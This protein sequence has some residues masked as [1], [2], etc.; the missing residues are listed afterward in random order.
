M[1]L[2]KF[3]FDLHADT[4]ESKPPDWE[5]DW[6]DAPLTYK[7]YRRRPVVPLSPEVPLTL[8]G[9]ESPAGPDL[10]AIGHLLWHAYG[11]GR[12][13][14]YAPA[15]SV[16]S[17]TEPLQLYRR[18]VPSGGGLYPNELYVY[19]KIADV[20][21]GIYHYDAAH[22]RLA[23][24]REGNF[25][26]YLSR[27]LGNRCDMPGCFAAVFVSVMFWKNFYKYNNFAYRLQGLDSGVLI[28]QLL[29]VAKRFGFESGVY[30]QFLDRAIHHLLGVT[31]REESV[32]AIVPLSTGPAASW[33]HN[34][35]NGEKAVFASDLCRELPAVRHEHFVRSQNVKEY[36]MLARMNEASMLDRA[37]SFRCV[38]AAGFVESGLQAI[39][40]PSVNRL[41]YDLATVCRKRY[42]P[43]GEFVLSHI[44]L[45]NAA[46]LLREA[47]DSLDY[48]NDLN[49]SPDKVT[50]R[51]SL[52]C[53]L[54]NVE[55][56]PDGAYRYDRATHS[57]RRILPGDHRPRLQQ[58]MSLDNI[59]LFQVPLCLHVA[60]D[61][62]HLKSVLG[63]RGYRI[64]QM[65]AG[66]LVHRLLLSA[67]AVGM[68]GRPLL[69]FH[70]GLC[71][72]IYKLSPSG[73]TSLIQI[74]IGYYRQRPRLEGSL[75]S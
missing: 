20:P 39:Y 27:A 68:G 42:S 25:D 70:S 57:L 22:H 23:S 47:A 44:K 19:L 17:P 64:Q 21:A 75:H 24:L 59:N 18:F 60:G 29:E 8:A 9:F 71:D 15:N 40:M 12:L 16:P 56:I 7:L 13:S 67:A 62:D 65:E 45:A 28:G 46:A 63:Y 10:S 74:P 2:E 58:G 54:Y 34:Q 4:F 31:E 32:Y 73:K 37:D 50:N 48:H 53:C 33:F 30:Y 49:E 66:L 6:D 52:Y 51:L 61:R 1:S 43:E 11:L 35:A 3:V 26:D 72:E 14:Q 69:G 55:G 41:S 36:P 38:E 5:I